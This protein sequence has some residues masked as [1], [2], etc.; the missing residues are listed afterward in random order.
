MSTR[1]STLSII[2]IVFTL[3]LPCLPISKWENEFAST[4][5]LIGYEIIWWV[6]IAG[7]LSYVL[8][9]E[10]RPL[11][12]IGFRTIRVWDVVWGV[13]AGVLILAA[14]TGIHFGILPA[15]HL[16]ED[17][18]VNTLLATPL[19]WRFISVIRAAVGEEV[20]FRGYAIERTQ[21]VTGSKAL[22]AIL[23]CVV[24][25][26]AHLGTWG[27]GHLLIAGFGGIVFTLL[28]L[29]RRNIWVNIIAHFIVDGA[30]VLLG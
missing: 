4:P 22:A 5:H 11:S 29:W 9:A 15:L 30:S 17:Q 7:V 6:M 20:L 12:S 25:T 1:N 18:Q 10:K 14:L 27:W 8:F 24:F 13:L 2:G 3:G 19:W 16:T 28:Y 23:S 26:L 21:E